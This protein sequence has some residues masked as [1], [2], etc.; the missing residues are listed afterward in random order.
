MIVPC[1]ELMELRRPAR[2]ASKHSLITYMKGSTNDAKHNSYDR[3]HCGDHR[4]RCYG[5]CDAPSG[6]R[7]I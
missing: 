5:L 4:M 2:G 3:H 6:A 7:M 1:A